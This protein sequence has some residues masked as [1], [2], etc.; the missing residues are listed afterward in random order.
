MTLEEFILNEIKILKGAK[1]LNKGK[2][3][4][5]ED[6]TFF[7]NITVETLDKV[8]KDFWKKT[9]Q[10][11]PLTDEQ[12]DNWREHDDIDPTTGEFYSK[13]HQIKVWGKSNRH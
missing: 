8:L 7:I 5:R 13:A 9:N 10:A 1:K 4:T 2:E 3:G 6:T 12:L 11:A